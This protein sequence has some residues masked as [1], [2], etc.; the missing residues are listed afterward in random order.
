MLGPTI[1]MAA[2]VGMP[3][4]G[5]RLLPDLFTHLERARSEFRLGH[6]R[7]AS[8]H[9]ELIALPEGVRLILEPS[10]SRYDRVVR[11]AA[12]LW[13][14]ALGRPDLFDAVDAR[15]PQVRIRIAS[16]VQSNGRNVGGLATW[17]RRVTTCGDQV[18]EQTFQADI[19]I[20]KMSGPAMLQAIAH[21]L[22]HVLG[23]GDSDRV[24]EVMGPIDLRRPATE[25]SEGDRD[26]LRMMMSRAMSYCEPVRPTP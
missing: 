17:K 8:A 5:S 26:A 16:R 7:A 22:G 20:R 6:V 1:V 12:A 23:L 24:G 10:S 2:V 9:A 19:E 3:V 25:L 15:A 13:E 4:T 14:D 11:D 18:I 21:E